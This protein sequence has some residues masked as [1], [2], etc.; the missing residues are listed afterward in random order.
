MPVHFPLFI[1]LLQSTPPP[2]FPPA[3]LLVSPVEIDL[4][5][6]MCSTFPLVWPFT[7]VSFLNQ[8]ADPDPGHCLPIMFF[9]FIRNWIPSAIMIGRNKW[10][11]VRVMLMQTQICFIL[12]CGTGAV[13]SRQFWGGPGADYFVRSEPEQLFYG[14]SGSC[15]I[16]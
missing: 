16:F 9:I 4:K 1:C 11:V 12:C 7:N 8:V 6:I 5:F 3:N 14:G 10:S 15:R 13:W 2:P